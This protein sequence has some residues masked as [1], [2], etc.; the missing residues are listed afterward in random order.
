MPVNASYCAP[1]PARP[2]NAAGRWLALPLAAALLSA[3]AGGPQF[4]AIEPPEDG[5]AVVYVYRQ[6]GVF[7]LAM[8]PDIFV[9]GQQVGDLP[10]GGYLRVE[11]P[12]PNGLRRISVGGRRCIPLGGETFA[13]GSVSLS[14]GSTAYV[15]LD[16]QVGSQAAGDRYV[17]NNTC[18][19]Q[20][21]E[22]AKALA[23]LP[24][25]KLAH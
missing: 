13:P 12:M 8:R 6:H 24:S 17:W 3:C 1:K 2:I 14:P 16:I 11:V 15:E 18:R 21:A 7:G 5:N 10:A 9:D 20:L 19:L 23:I 4:L 22:P 25:L